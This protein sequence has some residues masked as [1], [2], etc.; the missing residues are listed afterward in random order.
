[1][2]IIPEY[3]IGGYVRCIVDGDQIGEM[4]RFKTGDIIQ[5]IFVDDDGLVNALQGGPRVYLCPE[6]R[7]PTECEYI[8]LSPEVVEEYSIF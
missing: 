7:Y 2:K 3:E 4:N 6:G 5:I 1:M 8:G